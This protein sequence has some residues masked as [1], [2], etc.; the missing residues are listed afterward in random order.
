MAL[1]NIFQKVN[2]DLRVINKFLEKH[3]KLIK[4]KHEQ[5]FRINAIYE[6]TLFINSNFNKFNVIVK[7]LT[8]KIDFE[9]YEV[10]K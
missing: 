10:D 2:F 5:S 1:E 3:L 4:Q 7:N 8:K 9:K 6:K